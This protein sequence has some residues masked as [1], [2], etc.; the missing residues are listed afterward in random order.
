MWRNSLISDVSFVFHDGDDDEKFIIPAH[1]YVLAISS[2]VFFKMFYGEAVECVSAVEIADSNS[3]SF[4]EF[5]RFVYCDEVYFKTLESAGDLLYLARKYKLLSLESTCIAYLEEHLVPGNVFQ[6]LCLAQEYG[7]ERLVVSCWE[8]VD[9][10]TTEAVNSEWFVKIDNWLLLDLL[11]RNCLCVREIDLFK[12]VDRWAT[13]HCEGTSAASHTDK[14]DK[15]NVTPHADKRDEKHVTCHTDKR[16]KENVTSHSD[17]RDEKHVTC[18]TDKRDKGNVTPHADK[19]DE[20]HVTC[21]TDKRDKGNVTP[22]ADKRDKKH[23]TCHTDKRDEENVTS[24][25]YKRDNENV[26][27]HSDKRDKENVTSHSDK[28]DKRNVLGEEIVKLLRFPTMSLEEFAQYVPASKVLDEEEVIR[29]FIYFN[30]PKLTRSDFCTNPR[31]GTLHRCS[32][33]SASRR[34]FLYAE[35]VPERVSFSVDTPVYFFGVRLFGSE[36]SQYTVKLQIYEN[37]T[38]NGEKACTEGAYSSDPEQTDDYY[39]FDVTLNKAVP[40]KKDTVYMVE[41][42]LSGPPSG[43]GSGGKTNVQCGDVTFTFMDDVSPVYSKCRAGQF[44][45]ILFFKVV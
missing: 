1:K 9:R 21:H 36:N 28:R 40:L 35:S 6:V 15:G 24:R 41:A 7:E 23:V 31:S 13:F 37:S 39:G 29:L 17:K 12:A 32:R 5:L 38:T 45:E 16:D 44:A 10:H 2:S 8:I 18:H 19:R 33:F 43:Y 11:K 20:K 3:A 14:R 42:L 26:T 27:P 30:S 22:H 25:F 4:E 34:W